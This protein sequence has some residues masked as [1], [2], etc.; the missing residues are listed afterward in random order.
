MLFKRI[1]AYEHMDARNVSQF[2][3]FYSYMK[4]KNKQWNKNETVVKIFVYYCPDPSQFPFLYIETTINS[5]PIIY[6]LSR[7]CH[8]RLL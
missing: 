3:R 2:Q 5:K 8:F 1:Q 7:S 6:P 4:Q